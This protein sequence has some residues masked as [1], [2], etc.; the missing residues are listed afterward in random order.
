MSIKSKLKNKAWFN[1]SLVLSLM[2]FIVLT[3]VALMCG[4]LL[5]LAYKFGIIDQPVPFVGTLLLLISCVAVGT[6]E[7]AFIC[8]RTLRTVKTINRAMNEVAHGNFSIR[9]RDDYCIDEM[10]SMAHSFNKMAQELGSSEMFRSDF[11]ANVSHEFKTPLSAIE[12]YATLL[13]DDSLTDAER[14]EYIRRITDTTRSLSELTGN[15]LY[16]SRIENQQINP[17]STEFELDEQIREVILEL[18]AGWSDKLIDL[19]IDLDSVKCVG[20]QQM[21]RL[22]WLNL[23]QNAVKY[24]PERGSISVRLT[25]EGDRITFIVSDTGIGMSTE[26][27]KHIFEKFYKA[28]K[29]RCSQGNGLGLSLAKRVI[30][31]CSGQITVESHPDIGSTFTVNIPRVI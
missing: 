14:D 4:A 15:I 22:V 26:V 7:A 24:T 13:S 16:L 23:L 25:C 29:S 17:Q 20:P 18:E 30:D 1:L 3:S 9:I 2:S 5:I 12:G 10:H 11:I 31:A 21:L 6:V 27:Q 19:N 8:R 28:D